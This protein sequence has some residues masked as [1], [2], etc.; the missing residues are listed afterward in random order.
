MIKW[1]TIVLDVFLSNK[2]VS[3]VRS[4]YLFKRRHFCFH[5]LISVIGISVKRRNC[6][7][8]KEAFHCSV[9]RKNVMRLKL[10][11]SYHRTVFMIKMI[12]NL[13]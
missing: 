9:C 10:S 11:F 1:L 8:N 2:R 5:F 4:L 12:V 3:R 6:Y 13:E 7:L